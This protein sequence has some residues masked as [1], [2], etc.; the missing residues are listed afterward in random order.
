MYNRLPAADG[1]PS[2]FESAN[3]VPPSLRLVHPFGSLAM[4]KDHAA[5]K[6]SLVSASRKC[7]V[8]GPAAGTKDSFKIVYLDTNAVAH[9]RDLRHFDTEFPFNKDDA[10][11]PSLLEPPEMVSSPSPPPPGSRIVDP[12]LANN[13]FAVLS[14]LDGGSVA[15]DRP[16]RV[17]AAPAPVY[18]PGACEAQRRHDREQL[19][20]V[21]VQPEGDMEPVSLRAALATDAATEWLSAT[22]SELS[23]HRKNGTWSVVSSLPRGRSAIPSRFVFKVKRGPDGGILKYKCRLVA[24]GFRQ[25]PLLDYQAT[26]SPTLRTST[27]R[28]LCALACQLSLSFHQMDVS[29]AFL[30]PPLKEE[31]Y[32]RL[33]EQDL[34]DQNLPEY[35]SSPLVRLNKTLYGLVQSPRE[36]YLHLSKILVG[37]G[38][39]Q[40]AQDPCLWLCVR[41]G[42]LVCAIAFYVDDICVVCVEEEI[43]DFKSALQRNFEMTD[44]GQI[45]WFLGVQVRRDVVAGTFALDQSAAI[46]RLLVQH[47]MSECAA[48]STPMDARLPVDTSPVGQEERIFMLGKPYRALVGSLLYLLFTRPDLAYAVNQ[49]TRHLADPRRCHWT[50]ALRV[51][52]YLRGTVDLSLC[53]RREEETPLT[54]VGYA[55]ASWGECVASRR[56]TTGYVFL[57]CGAAI[58]WKTKL[59][60]SVALS[61]CEAELMALSDA[62]REAIWLRRMSGELVQHFSSEPVPI[63]EDNQA[64]RLL[65][66]DQRFSERTKH[67]ALRHFFVREEVGNGTIT[68]PYCPTNL[69]VADI[70][71]KALQRV[72]FERFRT[73]LGLVSPKP[74]SGDPKS[75]D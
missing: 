52:K 71:T 37:M 26:F 21:A 49:L 36:F 5:R 14:D 46:S 59:Q 62:G 10:R 19:A 45:S 13:P 70:F 51:L 54:L 40:S 72:A 15:G 20:N 22:R 58:S 34:V 6:S 24:K 11:S 73:M 33:P 42:R 68:V 32:L 44:G 17:P 27:F 47:S 43:Q 7:V 38:L 28:M 67:V 2:P 48:V 31:I 53:F 60:T 29:T 64:A 69:M 50:A 4:A 56:S 63:H 55:D 61:T 66:Q 39:T 75:S 65:V 18:Q 9:S 8:L 35:Q 41:K 1:Q 57:L 3:G 12:A 25:R 30:V 16:R 74:T 23:A